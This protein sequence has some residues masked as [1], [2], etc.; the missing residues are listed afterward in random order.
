MTALDRLLADRLRGAVA[1]VAAITVVSGV[2]QLALPGVVLDALGAES[3]PTTRH[4]FAIVGMF[5]A[6]VG[7]VTLHA[8]VTPEPPAYVVLWAALQKAGAVTAV[9][10]GVARDLFDPLALGVAGFDLLSAL[11]AAALWQRLRTS[12]VTGRHERVTA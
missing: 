1:A 7:A 4:L 5:M 3:T 12:A 2:G 8:L 11:L 9:G 6:V 10:I